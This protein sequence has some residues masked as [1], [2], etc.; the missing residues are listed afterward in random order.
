MAEE[1]REKARVLG[2]RAGDG[3]A[4]RLAAG[5][6]RREG[7]LAAAPYHASGLVR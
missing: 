5:E 1:S 3:D 2:E 6:P 4:L 7:V